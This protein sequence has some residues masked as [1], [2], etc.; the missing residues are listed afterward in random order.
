MPWRGEES[1][2]LA[3]ASRWTDAGR[4]STVEHYDGIKENKNSW[5]CGTVALY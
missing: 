3:E 5:L 4:T 2:G 1:A